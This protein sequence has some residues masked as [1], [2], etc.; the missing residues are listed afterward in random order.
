M[1]MLP[2][3]R[4]AQL[5]QRMACDQ[6]QIALCSRRQGTRRLVV[7]HM[8]RKTTAG[9]QVAPVVSAVCCVSASACAA[10][11]WS[12]Y[13]RRSSSPSSRQQPGADHNGQ[14]PTQQAVGL[15]RQC[16]LTRC[17]AA[18]AAHSV[19]TAAGHDPEQLAH[20]GNAEGD[21]SSAGAHGWGRRSPE[22][23]EAVDSNPTG[24]QITFLGTGVS[25]L[26]P[27]RRAASRV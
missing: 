23:S 8:A 14:P 22:L 3:L 24:M 16:R 2:A 5:S 21:F 4:V 18:T 10:C 1:T 6:H 17:K 13:A 7:T 9:R 15:T 27:G 19:A 26:T 25:V 12:T 20:G 11:A